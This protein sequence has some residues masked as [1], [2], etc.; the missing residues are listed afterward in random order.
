MRVSGS[1]ASV[2]RSIPTRAGPQQE[3]GDGVAAVDIAAHIRIGSGGKKAV[4]VEVGRRGF[5]EAEKVAVHVEAG[6]DRVPRELLAG[7]SAVRHQRARRDRVGL[8]TQIQVIRQQELRGLRHVELGRERRREPELGHIEAI[9]G[10]NVR[11]GEFTRADQDS[12]DR[13]RVDDEGVPETCA[14][15]RTLA[16]AGVLNGRV[17]GHRRRVD[18]RR[19]RETGEQRMAVCAYPIHARRMAIAPMPL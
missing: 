17:E 18:L 5:D 6:L 7:V 15:A 11:L 13:G 19:L 16:T 1:G 14:P 4:E 8:R 12:K 9:A 3:R 10:W 2:A